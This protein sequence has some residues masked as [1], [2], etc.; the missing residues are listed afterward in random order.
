MVNGYGYSD[1]LVKKRFLRNRILPRKRIGIFLR[2]IPCLHYSYLNDLY[3]TYAEAG[4]EDD[5]ED[6]EDAGGEMKLPEA[7]MDEG[8]VSC[9]RLAF[10]CAYQ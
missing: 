8:P 6:D 7:V 2:K 9:L 4:Y 3:F 10:C 5:F 1:Y